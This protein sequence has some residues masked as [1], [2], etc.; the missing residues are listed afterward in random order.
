MVCA[1]FAATLMIMLGILALASAAASAAPGVVQDLPGC[2]TSA[3]PADDDNFTEDPVPFGFQANIFDA[4]YDQAY[5]NNNGNITFGEPLEEFTPFDF[6]ET[7]QP[8]IAPFFADVDTRG[9]GVVNYGTVDNYGGNKAFCVIWDN[10]GYYEA[11]D[12]KLNRFQLLLV[13]RGAAGVDVI[14]NYDAIIWETGDF[15]GGENGFGGTSAAAGWSAAD[16]DAAHALLFPGSFVNGGLLD[17]NGSTSVAGHSTAG[18]PAGRYVF[19]LRQGAPTGG[20][21]EGTVLDPRLVHVPGAPVQICRQGGACVTRTSNSDGEYRAS[22]LTAGTYTIT[23]FPPSSDYTSATVS[24]V[25]V[26]GPDDPPTIQDVMLGGPPSPPPPGTEIT[27]IGTNDDGIPV[28]YWGDPLE[29]TTTGC[30]GAAATYQVV[31]HGQVV[32]SGSLAEGDPGIYSA[33]IAPLIPNSGDGEVN[34]ELDCPPG[35]PDDVEE[36]DFGIYIDPSGVI[37]DTKG[38]PIEG[39]IVTLFRSAT[40]QGPFFPVADGSAIMS[41]SNRANPDFSRADGRFGWDVV[42]GYYVVTAEKE[43]CVSAADPAR[44]DAIT[45]V[46]TIPP[47]VTDLDLRLNCDPPPVTTTPPQSTPGPQIV[48]D[49]PPRVSSERRRLA[50]IR[51]A[52]LVKGK[53][54]AVKIA[55]AASARGA[56]AGKLTA[57]IGKK[58]AGSK[59]F[60]KL[61]PGKVATVRI[62][63]TKKGK[64]LVRRVRKGKKVKFA[65]TTTV[66]D[67]AGSGVAP[68]RTVAVRR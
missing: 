52:K 27:N 26:R 49:P 47:P 20:R 3:L 57:R 54:L 63:L 35:S 2:R 50:T 18:Q 40:P 8:I 36:V 65:L 45:G 14:F 30:E 23:A 61:A 37:R 10:V 48:V 60:K 11:H 13:D 21:L 39:A 28:A 56:C 42:A 62:A 58:V 41:P 32:R 59:S 43:G 55:C 12:D 51:S 22:N 4:A 46:M 19:E 68:K 44:P 34:I 29:L 33:T 17:S 66:K 25:T 24:N 6:R 38:N 53:A 31:L 15:S 67:A 64:A 7:G 9:T 1:R 5:V 16:G